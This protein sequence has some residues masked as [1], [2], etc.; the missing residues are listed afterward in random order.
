M[1]KVK[2]YLLTIYISYFQNLHLIRYFKKCYNYKYN[3]AFDCDVMHKY[4]F[5]SLREMKTARC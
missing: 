4:I 3:F 1:Q 5:L 2:E